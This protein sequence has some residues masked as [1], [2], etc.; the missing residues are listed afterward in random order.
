MRAQIDRWPHIARFL[1]IDETNGRIDHDHLG[2]SCIEDELT[3]AARAAAYE[4]WAN[5]HE[6]HLEQ[7][8]AEL[9]ADPVRRHLVAEWTDSMAYSCRRSAAFA[10]GQHPGPWTPLLVRRP[11]LVAER[12]SILTAS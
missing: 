3:P 11:D 1:R 9:A 7:R 2:F 12:R 8:S 10:R 5:F 4:E 6:W